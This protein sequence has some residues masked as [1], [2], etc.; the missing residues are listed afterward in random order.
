[1]NCTRCGGTGFLNL[2]QVEREV[3]DKGVGAVFEWLA[4]VE[5]QRDRLGG[6]SCHLNPPC[7]YCM[8]LHDVSV[9]DCCGDGEGHYGEPGEH[10]KVDGRWD[11]GHIPGCI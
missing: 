1:M 8:L 9:C 10:N 5:S 3:V 7:S 6:C 2:D 11:C 4:S